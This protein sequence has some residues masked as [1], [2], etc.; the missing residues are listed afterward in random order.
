MRKTNILSE[1]L[2]ISKMKA[3]VALLLAPLADAVV[4]Y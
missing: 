3:R 2:M 4:V 1:L